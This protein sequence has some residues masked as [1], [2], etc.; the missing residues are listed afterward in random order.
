MKIKVAMKSP[1]ATVEPGTTAAQAET[2]LAAAETRGL[3]VVEGRRLV[4]MVYRRDLLRLQ[5]STVPAL[6]RYELAFA[7]WFT[8][9]D[10]HTALQEL[11]EITRQEPRNPINHGYLGYVYADRKDSSQSWCLSSN[12]G[13]RPAFAGSWPRLAP[14]TGLR[15][16]CPPHSPSPAVTGRDSSCSTCCHRYVGGWPPSWGRTSWTGSSTSVALTRASGSPPPCPRGWRRP[17]P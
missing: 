14:A 8:E 13:G 5:P 7:S 17:W 2:L 6:A 11:R 9:D 1:V 16:R 4:G 10:H 15:P 12:D 3:P